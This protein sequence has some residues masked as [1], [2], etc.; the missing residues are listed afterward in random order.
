[1]ISPAHQ[2]A[3]RKTPEYKAAVVNMVKAAH[4]AGA[5]PNQI[6]NFAQ[7]SYFP[8]PQQWK[9]HAAARIADEEDGPLHIAMGGARG[10]AKSHAIMSQVALDDCQRYPGLDVLYLRLIQKAGRKALDQL[11]SKTIMSLRH[12]Y[13]RNEGMISFANGSSIVVG[14]FKNEGDIDKYIGIEYDIIVVE[15][16]TQL[17][18]EKIDQLMGSLRTGKHGWRPRSYNA[19]NPGGIGHAAFRSTFVIPEREGREKDTLTAYFKMDWRHNPF[20]NPEYKKY[21]M[22]LTGILGEMWRDG[23]WD[24]GSG[25]YF[26]NWD[27]AV[28]VIKPLIRVPLEWPMWM[29]L[30]WGWTHPACF[31][32]HTLR[33]DGAVVTVSEYK[34]QRKLVNEHAPKLR[35]ITRKWDRSLSDLNGF[36]AGHD[37]FA[38]K[39]Q[40]E[41]T[42][43]EQFIQQGINWKPAILDRINGA[44]ELTARLGNP[45]EGLPATWFITKNC[46]D[47]VATLPNM[48]IDEKRPEDVLK[49]DANEFGQ[50]GDDSYDCAR[51]GLMVQPLNLGAGGFGWRY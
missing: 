50:G 35:E 36:V 44:G 6:R 42:I 31:Q 8:T 23:N 51:Y 29:S 17:S 45:K 34:I 49:V 22:G 26:I 9:Y 7:A 27:P 40:H 39:G 24:I 12:T 10:G 14:H 25:T 16:R 47:L 48:I 15:E 21:L 2:T 32:W 33:P 1:M 20:I 30:D 28:H 4:A 37:I 41:Q 13:N 46:K 19:S 18:Q 5:P 11:R 43:A 38:Q 3:Y